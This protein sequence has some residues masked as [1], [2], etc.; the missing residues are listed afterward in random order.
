[1]TLKNLIDATMTLNDSNFVRTIDFNNILISRVNVTKSETELIRANIDA[2]NFK[3]NN[4][5]HIT[6]P[7]KKKSLC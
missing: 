4:M 7:R 1:M 6:L 3:L 5:D 2:D